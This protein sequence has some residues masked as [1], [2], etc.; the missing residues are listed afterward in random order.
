MQGSLALRVCRNLPCDGSLMGQGQGN[1]NG[2]GQGQRQGQGQGQGYGL[3]T[4]PRARHLWLARV[5]C[6]RAIP[7]PTRYC[8]ADGDSGGR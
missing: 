5:S 1:S 7:V 8:T 2:Q 3:T 6:G 4:N